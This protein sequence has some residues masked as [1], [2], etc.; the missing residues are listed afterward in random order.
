VSQDLG[1]RVSPPAQF[2]III[3]YHEIKI[4]IQNKRSGILKIILGLVIYYIPTLLLYFFYN[5]DFIQSQPVTMISGVAQVLSPL[6]LMIALWGIID[7]FSKKNLN[8]EN[9]E[10]PVEQENKKKKRLY[11]GGLL[12]L[13]FSGLIFILWMKNSCLS[14]GTT[15]ASICKLINVLFLITFITWPASLFILIKGFFIKD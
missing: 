14:W 6:G 10:E 4:M 1:V 5:P 15:P 13:F 7:I 3:N 9:S 8:Q 2:K 12:M 11:I